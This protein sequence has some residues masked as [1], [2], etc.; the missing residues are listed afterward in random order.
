MAIASGS[1]DRTA[2]VK[3]GLGTHAEQRAVGQS[4]Q[5][6]VVSEK[7]VDRDL[8]PE[9]AADRHGYPQQQQVKRRQSD[10]QRD[11]EPVQAGRHV[12]SDGR[13]GQVDLEDADP[14][15]RSTGDRAAA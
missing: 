15:I 13:E 5:R 7:R 10:G 11:V 3:R 12:P 9:P 14:S 2:R 6:V 4:G 1:L 8:A